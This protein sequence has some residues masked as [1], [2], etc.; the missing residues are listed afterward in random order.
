MPA[1]IDLRPQLLSASDQGSLPQCAAYAMAGIIEFANWK[2]HD[3][4]E[5][6]DPQPI[7][8]RAKQLDAMPEL[9][10]TTLEAV[11][12]AAQE[13]DLMPPLGTE[14]LR[15][16][17]TADEVQSAVHRYGVILAAFQITDQ[18]AFAQKDG[19]IPDGGRRIGGHAVLICGYHATEN[20][21]WI[22]IANSWGEKQGWRGFNRLNLPTFREQ[23]EYGLVF[24]FPQ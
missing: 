4:Y 9:S 5:Q 21:A 12:Q 18:W 7:Y 20:P 13:L 17:S 14:R 11:L 15:T 23:F 6:I 22:A 16:V 3:R 10:G 2:Y 24:D 8:S 19:W 1:W